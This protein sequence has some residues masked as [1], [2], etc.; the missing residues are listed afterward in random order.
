MHND[1]SQFP[2]NV[3]NEPFDMLFMYR[4]LCRYP[5]LENKTGVGAFLN[6]IGRG[7]KGN[8]PPAMK[9]HTN[10]DHLRQ[11]WDKSNGINFAKI[12]KK[13]IGIHQISLQQDRV[14]DIYTSLHEYTDRI[15]C[16]NRNNKSLIHRVRYIGGY[17]WGGTVLMDV[18]GVRIRWVEGNMD[19][20]GAEWVVDKG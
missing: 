13:S 15:S 12:T 2:S 4:H 18:G 7:E 19:Q 10:Q 8:M 1:T 20:M 17:A 3:G 9:I 6:S 16:M 11:D 5:E 14:T